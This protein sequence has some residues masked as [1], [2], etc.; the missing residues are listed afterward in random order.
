MFVATSMYVSKLLV[1][2]LFLTAVLPA[3]ITKQGDVRVEIPRPT[4]GTTGII[5]NLGKTADFS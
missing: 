1:N 5:E 3:D 4:C 2:S